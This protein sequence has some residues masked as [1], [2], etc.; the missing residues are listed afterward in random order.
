MNSTTSRS[1]SFASST[2]ATS[3]QR[4]E[5]DEEGAISCGFVRGMYWT[6]QTTAT[7]I[8]PMKM[9]GS[10]VSAK[11]SHAAPERAAVRRGRARRRVVGLDAGTR[12]VPSLARERRAR[13]R[14]TSSPRAARRPARAGRARSASLRLV[15][16]ELRG[17]EHRE[18]VGPALEAQLAEL[19]L[20]AR[21]R[22]GPCRRPS[23]R[24]PRPPEQPAAPARSGR[25]AGA[26][27]GGLPSSSTPIGHP[28]PRHESYMTLSSRGLG[29]KRRPA[30]AQSRPSTPH[31]VGREVVRALHERRSD[32]VRVD[33]RAGPLEA[34]RSSRRRSRR[35]RRCARAGG[36]RRRARRARA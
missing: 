8:R 17:V 23:R 27:C 15:A 32:A 35:R 1:S 31:D 11:L 12:R 3:S 2:P 20:A 13:R 10:Q 33:R 7:A 19:L 30:L 16:V 6:I 36:R 28:W 5:L 21:S 22:T 25:R 4:T 26:G 18:L 9:I 14:R 34:R 29:L 24:P